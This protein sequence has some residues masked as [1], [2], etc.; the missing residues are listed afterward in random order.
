[1]GELTLAVLTVLS[2]STDTAAFAA[3]I[4]ERRQVLLDRM[5]G[6]QLARAKQISSVEWASRVWVVQRFLS[7]AEVAVRGIVWL[8]PKTVTV[9]VRL[10]ATALVYAAV[11]GAFVGLTYG[12]ITR[13]TN[14]PG[15]I[16][17]TCTRICVI[18][19]VM[20]SIGL[21][22]F[23]M[24]VVL[25]G[26]ADQWPRRSIVIGFAAVGFSIAAA[27]LAQ[28][29]SDKL[30]G[31]SLINLD[32]HDPGTIRIMAGIIATGFLWLC[33]H[34]GRTFVD[35]RFLMSDRIGSLGVIALLVSF[36]I[37][38]LGLAI[39][40]SFMPTGVRTAGLSVFALSMGLMLVSA[41]L[42]AGEWI[43]RH[44]WLKRQGIAVR[45]RRM[46][47]WL[48]TVAAITWTG[49]IALSSVHSMALVPVVQLAIIGFAIVA[50]L[51]TLPTAFLSWLHIRRVNLQY[52]RHHT[53]ETPPAQNSA[54]VSDRSELEA[55][56]TVSR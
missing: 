31:Q 36:S 4:N 22:I 35:R 16:F 6:R 17:D 7:R 46:L 30:R 12:W 3:D 21:L 15:S 33:A 54:A 56:S 44:R 42:G 13:D 37:L 55:A 53:D 25:F 9:I 19:V 47:R 45:G 41:L 1:M 8:V 5:G 52:E 39:S 40:G 24:L 38:L 2:G 43:G 29:V 23:R 14:D 49:G 27:A 18:S 51:T 26:P 10:T 20:G 11:I 28:F 34:A 48:L 32:S 50:F